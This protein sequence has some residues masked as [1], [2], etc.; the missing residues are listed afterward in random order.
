[1]LRLHLSVSSDCEPVVM[2]GVTFEVACVEGTCAAVLQFS[3][4][5]PQGTL[6]ADSSGI[7]LIVNVET[8]IR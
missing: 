5:A 6:S 8:T 3:N 4:S 7:N 2:Q 1:M